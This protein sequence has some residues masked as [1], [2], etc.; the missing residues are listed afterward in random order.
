MTG[1][2]LPG[3]DEVLERDQVVAV[4]R[5]DGRGRLLAHDH[6]GEHRPDGATELA[7]GVPA[8]VR[9]QR[10]S[11]DQCAPRLGHRVVAHV[12]EDQVVARAFLGE[13]LPRVVD[14][15]VGTE[16]ADQLDV[17]G[18]GHAGHLGTEGLR[19]LDGE[20]PHATGRPVDQDLLSGL[21]RPVVTQELE[22]GRGG[23]PEAAACSNV[24]LAGFLMRWSSLARAN[25]AKAPSHQP[26]T[27]S[28]GR[29]C[30]HRL[31]DRLDRPRDVGSGNRV[32][33]LAQPGRQAHDE[34]ASP[35]SGSSRRHGSRP[36]GR[37][38]GLR[39]GRS[40]A[41]R[42]PV[43][44]GPR[45]SHNCLE[46]SPASRFSLVLYAVKP[47]GCNVRCKVETVN[48]RSSGSTPPGAH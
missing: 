26:K 22:R 2:T 41:P 13:V 30:G 34:R 37:G 19:D 4:L 5:L 18:A 42:C 3:F 48:P 17:P 20:R 46:R 47:T 29:R 10:P 14:D 38:P 1:V 25:S 15:V 43:T 6:R 24:R 35:S 11:R 40:Q 27:S 9:D 44:A 16:R 8:A 21:D 12:V 33:R 23:D 39:C 36:H 45:S 28:P 31:A 32:L 7:V